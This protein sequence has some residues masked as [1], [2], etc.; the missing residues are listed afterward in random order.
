MGQGD[1]GMEDVYGW[2]EDGPNMAFKGPNGT[3]GD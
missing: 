2:T 1:P 3:T